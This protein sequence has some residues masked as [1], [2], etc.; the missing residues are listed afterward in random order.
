MGACIIYSLGAELLYS[1]YEALYYSTV[2]KPCLLL[3]ELTIDSSSS[4]AL[5]LALTKFSS[6]LDILPLLLS[7]LEVVPLLIYIGGVLYNSPGSSRVPSRR[8]GSPPISVPRG[9][10]KGLSRSS[11][12]PSLSEVTLEP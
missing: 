4:L 11:N 8:V 12:A 6:L 7:S 10:L 1:S 9:S 5:L 2:G 3:G